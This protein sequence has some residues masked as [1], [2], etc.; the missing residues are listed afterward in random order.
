MLFKALFGWRLISKANLNQP[1]TQKPKVSAFIIK[2]SFKRA[3]VAIAEALC[4]VPGGQDGKFYGENYEAT[5]FS[6]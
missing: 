5:G 2:V 4:S 6:G 3:L 1:R